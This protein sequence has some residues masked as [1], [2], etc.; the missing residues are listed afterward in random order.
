MSRRARS[1]EK[2]DEQLAKPAPK[3]HSRAKETEDGS[4]QSLLFYRSFTT[5]NTHTNTHS[6]FCT[7]I[8]THPFGLFNPTHTHTHT[9]THTKPIRSES[10]HLAQREGLLA[11]LLDLLKL[12]P[13]SSGSV[14]LATAAAK[15]TNRYMLANAVSDCVLY[16]H[17]Y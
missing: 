17:W 6:H 7:C 11:T 9:H 8:V 5:G 4:E 14:G 13:N 16:T 12:G 10:E 3:C 1:G 15:P 2:G